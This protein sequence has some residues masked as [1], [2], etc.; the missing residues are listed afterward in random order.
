MEAVTVARGRWKGTPISWVITGVGPF[1]I[2]FT[3]RRVGPLI[4]KS[5]REFTT[6]ARHRLRRDV[7]RPGH[8]RRGP[9]AGGARPAPSAQANRGGHAAATGRG[10]IAVE[11]AE[12]HPGTAADR[13]RLR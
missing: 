1:E 12:T 5:I 4:S 8:R 7:V 3:P 6:P 2:S 9:V 10:G 11:R 13:S